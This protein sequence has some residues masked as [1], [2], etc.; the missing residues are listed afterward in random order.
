MPV[1][2]EWAAARR[3]CRGYARWG[4]LDE[5][6]A[7]ALPELIRLRCALS[8]LWWLDR[9]ATAGASGVIPA[10]ITYLR[11]TARWLDRHGSRLVAMIM[12]EIGLFQHRTAWESKLYP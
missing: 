10:P 11:H 12:R 8:A 3:F 1:L 9:I 7:R 4:R 5:A 2:V 6:E